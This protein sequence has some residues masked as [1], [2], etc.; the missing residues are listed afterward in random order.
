MRALRMAL[1]S[2]TMKL[3]GDHRW[4]ACTMP[5]DP[6]DNP[7]FYERVGLVLPPQQP[8][9]VCAVRSV[10]G[11]VD[12]TSMPLQHCL[13]PP[14]WLLW[15]CSH[16]ASQEFLQPYL[17]GAHDLTSP[18]PSEPLTRVHS[19]RWQSPWTC[20]QC[21]PAWMPGGTRLPRRTWAVRALRASWPPCSSTGGTSLQGC[22]TSRLHTPCW[23]RPAP[24]WLPGSLQSLPS[25]VGDLQG[26]QGKVDVWGLASGLD[27]LASGCH[28]HPAIMPALLLKC[29]QTGLH[30]VLQD[31]AG[32]CDDPPYLQTRLGC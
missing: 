7:D 10:E 21:W 27:H 4:P 1:R 20:P 3:L 32:S 5:V 2:I 15:G 16:A 31:T 25:A 26:P 22:R 24:W 6:D 9:R 29:W 23:T 28:K 18:A 12:R 8:L 30:H 11:G 13:S 14:L 17:Q 19:A